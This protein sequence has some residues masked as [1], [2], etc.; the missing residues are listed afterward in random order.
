MKNLSLLTILCLTQLS[1]FSQKTPA[2]EVTSAEKLDELI[3]EL[4]AVADIPGLSL[5]IVKEGQIVYHEAF[6][7]RSMDTKE[8]VTD[9]T[10]FAAASLSKALFAYGL[11]TW[12]EAG[13]FDLDRPLYQYFPYEDLE[14]DDRYKQL[15]ARHVLSHT[16]GLP[17]WRRGEQLNFLRNPGTKFGYSGEGFVYLM[18]VIEHLSGQDINSFMTERVFKPLGMKRSSYLWREDFETDHAIPH[19]QFGITRRVNKPEFGNTAYSLQTTA[20]DYILFVKAMLLQQGLSAGSI[21][22]V[23]KSQVEVIPGIKEVQW[24]LGVGL[25][26]SRDGKAFWHWG[27][28][29][30][31]KAF[32]IAYPKQQIGLVY[33]ANS[34]NGLSIAGELVSACIGG[35]YPSIRWIDYEGPGAPARQLLRHIREKGTDTTG[36]PL[37]DKNGKHQ[38]TNK[39]SESPMNRLGYQLFNLGLPKAALEVL[40]MNAKAYPYSANAQDSHGEALLRNGHPW[41]AADAYARAAQLD[42]TNATAKAIVQQIRERHRSGNTTFVLKGYPYA[43]SVQL[44]GDFNQWNT[45][46]CPMLRENGQWITRIDLEPGYYEYQFMVDG[47]R[48]TDPGNQEARFRD[49]HHSVLEKE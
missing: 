17:N 39:I 45:L 21:A 8:P 23:L 20:V 3:P 31:F 28:N 41:K 19:D 12:V 11:M 27:D 9:Q 37:M 48:I 40:Q 32:F 38:D 2:L 34:S 1:L 16:S 5:A 42:T 47:I 46:T 26:T 6:G 15:T 18:K 43:R 7:V 49:G 44:I 22:Q 33:F 36:W 4:M 25:Q 35:D 24:G 13:K 30:T 29:G 14:H 10:I